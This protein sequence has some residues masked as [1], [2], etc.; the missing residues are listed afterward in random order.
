M[1]KGILIGN[2]YHF[3]E[4]FPGPGRG[5]ADYIIETPFT[6]IPEGRWLA[7]AH[8]TNVTTTIASPAR[9]EVHVVAVALLSDQLPKRRLRISIACGTD[10]PNASV[11]QVLITGLVEGRIVG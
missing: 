10:G 2:V 3:A 11:D 1:E 5:P 4:N 9:Y 7:A 8:L 6:A